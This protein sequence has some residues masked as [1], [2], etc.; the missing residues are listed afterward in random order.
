MLLMF[1]MK[2]FFYFFVSAVCALQQD[3]LSALQPPS[4]VPF[5]FDSCQPDGT[6]Y[7]QAGSFEEHAFAA[8]FE[9]NCTCV[10]DNNFDDIVGDLDHQFNIEVQWSCQNKCG[11]CFPSS[12]CGIFRA[13]GEVD[14]EGSLYNSTDFPQFFKCENTV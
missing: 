8:E 3:P 2:L 10:V 14:V 6:P 9:P 5:T 7:L 1:K 13:L 12:D 4:N 11:T